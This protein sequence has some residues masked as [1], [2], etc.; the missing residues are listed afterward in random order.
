MY[1][2]K[3]RN[4]WIRCCKPFVSISLHKWAMI[5][6][7]GFPGIV[8]IWLRTHDIPVYSICHSQFLTPMREARG[9]SV[10]LPTANS[11]PSTKNFKFRL[12]LK[13]QGTPSP[14]SVHCHHIRE[15]L[16]GTN[17]P[18][19]GIFIKFKWVLVSKFYCS[20]T[21]M[22]PNMSVM[23]FHILRGMTPWCHSAYGTRP[24]LEKML[25]TCTIALILRGR[26]LEARGVSV[27]NSSRE[28][29]WQ[30]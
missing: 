26:I 10:N 14:S 22:V 18:N 28:K 20:W 9:V 13:L 15:D 21:W 16:V 24:A 25:S 2:I 23:N 12:H 27:M 8:C 4:C 30:G 6:T 19:I 1:F 17:W 7:V 29:A 11:V 5:L 3:L